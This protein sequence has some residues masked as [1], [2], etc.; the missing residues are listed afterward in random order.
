MNRPDPITVTL[1]REEADWLDDV[2]DDERKEDWERGENSSYGHDYLG[3]A[4]ALYAKLRAALDPEATI[5]EEMVERGAKAM[6]ENE[7]GL[8]WPTDSHP[9]IADSYR[10][11]TRIC[12]EAALGEDE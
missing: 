6:W 12:L 11:S 5:T 9:K 4:D 3:I 1:T 2:L 10:R 7:F 8:S